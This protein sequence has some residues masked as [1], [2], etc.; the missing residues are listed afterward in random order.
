MTL[1]DAQ[2]ASLNPEILGFLR[3]GIPRASLLAER[4]SH[5]YLAAEC[6]ERARAV[7]GINRSR[8]G[9]GHFIPSRAHL[10]MK[11]PTLD[12]RNGATALE[13]IAA[14]GADARISSWTRASL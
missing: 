4:A 2:I 7:C 1:S 12:G 14:I 3:R 5:K 11:M 13:E 9:A 6:V 8:Y 10:P